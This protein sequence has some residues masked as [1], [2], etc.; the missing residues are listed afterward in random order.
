MRYVGIVARVLDD[1]RRRNRVGAWRA[2]RLQ[3]R[4]RALSPSAGRPELDRGRAG[5]QRLEGRARRPAGAGARRPPA[6]ER[7]RLA[8][9]R[10]RR[11]FGLPRAGPA[12]G[13]GVVR[14]R[15]AISEKTNIFLGGRVLSFF[16]GFGADRVS[17]NGGA[18]AA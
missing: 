3:A 15:S 13:R 5:E 7:R 16:A 17:G 2:R 9:S 6:L 12:E 10:V 14:P 18:N 1:S 11:G 4:T 8:H